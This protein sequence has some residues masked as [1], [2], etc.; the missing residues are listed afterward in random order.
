MPI[1]FGLLFLLS[2][3]QI[4]KMLE[5]IFV[6]SGLSIARKT[7]RLTKPTASDGDIDHGA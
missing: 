3:C 6:F 1:F 2:S 4:L 5:I 7:A